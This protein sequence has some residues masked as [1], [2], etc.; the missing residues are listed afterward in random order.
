MTTLTIKDLSVATELDRFAMASIRGGTYKGKPGMPSWMP[1][2]GATT[3]SFKAEQLIGQSQDVLNN[4]GN[5]VAFACDIG[6]TVNPTQTANNSI[7]F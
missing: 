3:A 1:G 7:N 6:S 2:Y 4:N 5:N